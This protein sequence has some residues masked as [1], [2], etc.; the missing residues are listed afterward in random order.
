M[1]LTK[2]NN[3][4]TKLTALLFLSCF[5]VLSFSCQSKT[6]KRLIGLWAVELD[7][8]IVQNRPW[9]TE[10]CDN[11]LII[12][13]KQECN[14]PALCGQLQQSKGTWQ[15]FKGK[16]APDTILFNVPE[17]PLR[18]QYA[19]TFYKDYNEMKFKMRLQN[20]STILICGKN[21]INFSSNNPK[22]IL[23]KQ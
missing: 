15:L 16:N 4:K 1:T 11:F 12:K 9:I 2:L 22:E 10:I 18:G 23:D 14:L 19:I 8:C 20:D 6:E 21:I 5:A 3:P 7:S 13:E 17:N